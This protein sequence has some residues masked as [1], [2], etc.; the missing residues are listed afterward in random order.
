[1]PSMLS[2][3]AQVEWKFLVPQ[4]SIVGLRQIDGKALAGYCVCYSRWLEAEALITKIGLLVVEKVVV[5]DQVVGQKI[6][7]NPAVSIANDALKL[8]KTFLVE[9]GMTP[10][11]RSRLRVGDPAEK[12]PFEEYLATGREQTE[13][14]SVN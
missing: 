2:P 11:A 1:M 12:D 3:V 6:R 10:A 14:T 7:R 5:G 4:L 13:K 9:F 8:M